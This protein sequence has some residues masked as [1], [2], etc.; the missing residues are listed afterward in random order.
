MQAATYDIMDNVRY[1]ELFD[2]MRELFI[3][4][5]A[6]EMGLYIRAHIIGNGMNVD[7]QSYIDHFL[8]PNRDDREVLTSDVLYSKFN[9]VCI[10]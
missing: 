8:F 2:L 7:S 1:A 10:L 6:A 5:F 4:S 3:E 9:F